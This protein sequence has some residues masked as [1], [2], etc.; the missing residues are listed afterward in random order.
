MNQHCQPCHGDSK[1]LT[2]SDITTQLQSLPDWRVNED[3]TTITKSFKF[4]NFIEC[5]VFINVVADI[6]EREQHHPD[7]SIHYNRCQLMLSTHAIGGLSDN[8]FIMAA[9][10]DDIG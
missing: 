9:F 7:I 3:S 10:I 1:P 5:M 2:H 6:A 8:D 4:K